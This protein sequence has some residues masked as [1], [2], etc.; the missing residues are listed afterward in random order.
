MLQVD[1]NRTE[2][3]VT[4]IPEIESYGWCL[5]K[6][7]KCRLGFQLNSTECIGLSASRE[8]DKGNTLLLSLPSN[9]SRL[10]VLPFVAAP[11]HNNAAA[12]HF[13]YLYTSGSGYHTH[14]S[15]KMF[16]QRELRRCYHH[17]TA[18][19]G[20][21]R[22]G[23]VPRY[24]SPSPALHLHNVSLALLAVLRRCYQPYLHSNILV[25]LVQVQLGP[26]VLLR[27]MHLGWR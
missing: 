9:T 11:W 6:D 17:S 20:A 15:H 13:A 16:A 4:Y 27:N 18:V 7:S 3:G 1:S 14:C 12:L 24:I 21:A 5:A 22:L 25:A 2:G 19:A 26:V 23:I 8:R 10:R